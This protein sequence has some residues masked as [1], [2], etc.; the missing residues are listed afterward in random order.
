MPSHSDRAT[1]G[2]AGEQ[3]VIHWLKEHGYTIL[4]R[5][6]RTRTGE[7]DII[8]QKE[9]VIAFIEVKYRQH[10]YFNLSSVITPQKQKK[11][12][13]TALWYLTKHKDPSFA[14]RFDVALVESK[15]DQPT[16]TYIENAYTTGTFYP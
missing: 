11:I 5:N 10:E 9:E 14:Y 7:I 2:A 13:K 8:A 15:N 4:E 1:L 6:Y 3:A 16:I 12:I